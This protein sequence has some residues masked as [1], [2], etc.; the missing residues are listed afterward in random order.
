MTVQELIEKLEEYDPD[1]NVHF[2][3]NYGDH[4]R[5]MVAP[6]VRNVDEHLVVR[7][8]YHNMPVIIDEDDSRYNEADHSVVVLFP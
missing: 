7:S 5:T 4:S 2:T 8:E 1:A 6:M 3:Y